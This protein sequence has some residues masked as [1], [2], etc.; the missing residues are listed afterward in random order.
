MK[1]FNQFILTLLAAGLLASCSLTEEPTSF[2]NRKSFYKKESKSI[3][4]LT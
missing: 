2:V 3:A 4:A 1:N